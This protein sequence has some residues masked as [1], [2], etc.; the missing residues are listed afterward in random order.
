V[1]GGLVET[2]ATPDAVIRRMVGAVVRK[3]R[4]ATGA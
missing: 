4:S 2:G 3:Y 1:T